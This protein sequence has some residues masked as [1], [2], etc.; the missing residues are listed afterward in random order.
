MVAW[1]VRQQRLHGALWG[2]SVQHGSILPQT[3]SVWP[4]GRLGLAH[5]LV[6]FLYP[7]TY[8]HVQ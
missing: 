7:L 6:Y 4:G 2:L 3:V 8:A 5:K 1:C